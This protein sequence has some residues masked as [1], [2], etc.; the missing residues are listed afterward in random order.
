M[1]PLAQQDLEPTSLIITAT[2]QQYQL[3]NPLKAFFDHGSDNTFIHERCLPCG[4]SPL[5]SGKANGNT[6]AETFSTDR[7]VTI[8]VNILHPEFH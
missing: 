5:I 2:I 3:A 8:L 7:S 1:L 4:T 6:L